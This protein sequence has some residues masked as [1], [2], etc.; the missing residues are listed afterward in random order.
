MAFLIDDIFLN[1]VVWLG[2]KIK[3]AAE[4][5]MLDES[6][7]RESLLSMQMQLEMGEITE[8][9]Y[10]IKETELMDKLEDIRKYKEKTRPRAL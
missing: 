10:Q 4:A 9:E 5:E 2:E 1:P 8:G 3:D 6:K 7:V